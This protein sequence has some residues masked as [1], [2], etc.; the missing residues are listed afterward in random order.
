MTKYDRLK[1][2]D[3]IVEGLLRWGVEVI[4]GLPGDGINGVIEALRRHQ[5]K[6][7]F[8]LVRHEES[9]AFMACAYA[10]YTGKLGVCVATSGPGATHLLTGLYDAK[11]DGVPVL[12]ITGNTYSDT[13]GTKYQQDVNLLQ[14]FSDVTIYN[15]MI[16]SPEHVESVIDIACRS[17][18]ALRGVS[19]IT[20]PIDTQERKLEGRYTRHNVG[21]HTAHLLSPTTA[22]R[23][24]DMV[25]L[26]K[27]AEILNAGNKIVLLVGQGALGAGD[28][29]IEVAK[30]LSAPVVKALLGKAVIPDDN[31]YSIGGLGLLGTE[32]AS[33]AMDEADTLLMI[34]TS[35]PYME[36][37]PKPGNARGVQIDLF[38]E[39]IGLRYPVEVGLVGDAK[40]T[41]DK[42]LPLLHQKD[43]KFLKSKQVSMKKWNSLIHSSD[44]LAEPIK[45]QLIATAVSD[46]LEDNAIISVDSGTNTIW[47][48]RYINIRE[49]MKFSLSGTLS[50]MA[51]GLPYAIASQIAFP[52]RQSVA[53]VGDGGFTMLMG[54]FATAVKYNLP[55]KVIIIKNNILGMIRW[56]QLAF[57]GNPEYGVEFSPIDFVKFAEA[58][59]GKGYSIKKPHEIKKVMHEA[60]SQNAPTIIEAYVDPFEPPMPPKMDIKLVSKMT[61]SFAKGE[62]YAKRIG[63][64]IFRNQIHET[65]RKIHPDDKK[66]N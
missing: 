58:C 6:I 31:M 1:T 19:H 59:G 65:L 39:K 29:V 22:A 40:R 54:E 27:A 18:L 25:L 21:G 35:F 38:P 64:T 7:K 41:L 48:A 4:F 53:F 9:A 26:E 49:G 28:Q 17:A 34:G 11:A 16:N 2:S 24:P 50:T 42:I 33:D 62:P 57:L 14:L 30:K 3:I 60:M 45:P 32:P 43:D 46:E 61:K 55:I 52:D 36:Y 23:I 47:A 5:D 56:E 51:C 15:N 12:A 10:K 13:M 63:L 44:P 8:I 66:D 37:L 20:I